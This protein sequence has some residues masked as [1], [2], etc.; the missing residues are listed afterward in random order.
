MLATVTER[1]RAI[2]IRRA[3]G[4]K[5]QD[6]ILQFLIEAVVQTSMG[7]LIGVTLGLGAV[8]LVPPVYRFVTASRLPAMIDVYSIFISVGVSVIVGVAFGLYPAWKASR[9]D[10]IEALRHE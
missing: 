9:L 5:R 6:I 3:L 8:F 4:A 1:T 10:P 7:G 2:A